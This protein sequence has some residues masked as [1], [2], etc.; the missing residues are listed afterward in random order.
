MNADVS[1]W[2]GTVAGRA[3]GC[4]AACCSA[5]RRPRYPCGAPPRPCLRYSWLLLRLYR[6]FPEGCVVDFGGGVGAL[7]A[8]MAFFRFC[9]WWIEMLSPRL[10]GWTWCWWLDDVTGGVVSVLPVGWPGRWP[11]AVRCHSSTQSYRDDEQEG[12]LL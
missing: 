12:Y 3:G 9:W 2:C 10:N 4:Y 8:Q 5:L 7:A 6:P 1:G 11:G